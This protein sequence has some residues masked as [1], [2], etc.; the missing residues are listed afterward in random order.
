MVA[1]AVTKNDGTQPTAEGVDC[2]LNARTA[3]GRFGPGNRFGKGRP[4]HVATQARSIAYSVREGVPADV[5][6]DLMLAIAAG[7]DAE[8]ARDED[9]EW[10]VAWPESGG[11]R[12]T[13]EQRMSAVR[14]LTDRGWGQ[15]ASV[16]Q[17]EAD[18]RSRAT[19]LQL[20]A[21]APIKLIALAELLGVTTHAAP[22]L[23]AIDVPALPAGDQSNG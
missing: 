13:L 4:R 9:G 21:I 11:I 16:V 18:V 3:G 15:A 1:D 22:A 14:W 6:R 23:P 2:S 5:L 12:P 7:H 8:L 19:T 17:V 20:D 10:G